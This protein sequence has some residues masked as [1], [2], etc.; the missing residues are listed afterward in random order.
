MLLFF[1]SLLK[2][3]ALLLRYTLRVAF[4]EPSQ[5]SDHLAYENN[6]ECPDV[7]LENVHNEV[8][9]SRSNVSNVTETGFQFFP[10]L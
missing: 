2:V 6:E 9:L 8:Q 7:F 3:A 5:N 10:S 1:L 4:V